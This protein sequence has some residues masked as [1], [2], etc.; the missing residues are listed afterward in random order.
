[1]SARRLVVQLA[2][3]SYAHIVQVADV[4][5]VD[6]SDVL[7]ICNWATVGKFDGT[8]ICKQMFVGFDAPRD[9]VRLTA[10]LKVM[11]GVNHARMV[12]LKFGDCDVVKLIGA[13]AARQDILIGKKHQDLDGIHAKILARLAIYNA[14]QSQIVGLKEYIQAREEQT[15]ALKEER[16]RIE[17]SKK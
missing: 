14:L 5:W 10:V 12:E 3:D 15:N 17:C 2:K 13:D 1:M 11:A 7:T 9:A 6:L 8:P 16:G 4:Y